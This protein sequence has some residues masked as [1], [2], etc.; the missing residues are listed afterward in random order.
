MLASQSKC[1]DVVKALLSQP[2]IDID[3]ADKV[4]L[5]CLVFAFYWQH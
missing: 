4:I 3:L 5:Y 2:N 1:A